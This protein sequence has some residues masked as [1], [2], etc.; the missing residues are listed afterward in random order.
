MK[1]KIIFEKKTWDRIFNDGVFVKR[2]YASIIAEKIQTLT[3]G[4]IFT[5]GGVDYLKNKIVVRGTC[6]QTDCRNYKV[7]IHRSEIIDNGPILCDVLRTSNSINHPDRLTRHV[8]GF[9]RD[10]VK[11][12]LRGIM[13]HVFQGKEGLRVDHGVLKN[14]NLQ[15]A[16]VDVYKKM[17][18][19]ILAERDNDADEILDILEEYDKYANTKEKY[20]HRVSLRPFTVHLFS[21]VGAEVLKTVKKRLSSDVIGY[22]DATGSI[23]RPPKGSTKAIFLY[24]LIVKIKNALTDDTVTCF[25]LSEMI[26]E[27][28]DIDSISSWLNSSRLYLENKTNSTLLLKRIVTDK[29]FANLNSISLSFNF[30]RLSDYLKLT[31]DFA[32]DSTSTEIKNIVLIHL[33]CSHLMKNLADDIRS[34][35]A[36][37]TEAKVVIELFS[38]IFNIQNYADIKERWLNISVL[39]LN[40]YNTDEVKQTLNNLLNTFNDFK[41]IEEMEKKEEDIIVLTLAEKEKERVNTKIL[42]KNSPWYQDLYQIS[43]NAN[44]KNPRNCLEKN[45]FFNY[46]LLYEQ[47]LKKYGAFLPLWSGIFNEENTRYSNSYVENYFGKLKLE[48]D[49]SKG[50]LGHGLLKASR[51][52]RFLRE[53]ALREANLFLLEIPKNRNASKKK[54]KTTRAKK[55][56]E[57]TKPTI[58]LPD[59]TELKITNDNMTVSESMQSQETWQKKFRKASISYFSGS[60]SRK[61]GMKLKESA[62]PLSDELRIVEEPDTKLQNETELKLAVDN[63]LQ[64]LDVSEVILKDEDKTALDANETDFK[65]LV[66]KPHILEVS[67]TI[68]EISSVIEEDVDK[69]KL[70]DRKLQYEN[71]LMKD[72]SYYKKNKVLKNYVVARSSVNSFLFI[73]DLLFLNGK[74]HL[75][76]FLI[77]FYL[78]L[79]TT[80]HNNFQYFNSF[81]VVN[82]ILKQNCKP[83]L[84]SVKFPKRFSI[85]PVHS[86][87]PKAEELNHWMLI[88]LDT[89]LKKFY[90]FNPIHQ[91]TQEK[92]AKKYFNKFEYFLN[93]LQVHQPISNLGEP[94]SWSIQLSVHNAQLDAHS[95]GVFILSFVNEF[96]LQGATKVDTNFRAN[97]KRMEMKSYILENSV[98]MV[99]YCL[100][101]GRE[102]E[103]GS[104]KKTRDD[105]VEC[106]KC[107]RWLHYKCSQEDIATLKTQMKDRF[108]YICPLCKR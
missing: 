93:E 59:V 1:E 45:R 56:T 67:K 3:T 90:F 91:S 95:C 69:T 46:K 83:F 12:R 62:L 88:I 29:S 102:D 11:K 78:D 61:F 97:D 4:C 2:K 103:P 37:E 74:N 94:K 58:N 14:Q 54:T 36:S 38:T 68:S 66:N 77:E 84:K 41:S 34:S 17:N 47:L 30:N 26:T 28:H 75:S 18:S 15:V 98:S 57:T 105:W 63:Q 96:I 108:E 82:N 106:Q 9:T 71:F 43:N 40:E 53:R 27:C 92:E 8:T 55:V 107:L 80:K 81:C 25:P 19:E 21:H 60:N 50:E 87:H 101:C 10:D 23:V 76:N 85:L 99:N 72:P 5:C 16:S 49:C 70:E 100:Q 33:C 13:P 32:L 52:I 65:I 79:V 7:V 42:Y 35:Y 6:K 24:V 51:F 64:I 86:L 48:I 89:H 20:I 22:T 39:L 44:K 104:Q 73:D 31:H